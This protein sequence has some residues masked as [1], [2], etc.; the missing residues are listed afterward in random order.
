MHPERRLLGC[1]TAL[2]C[3]L[4]TAPLA[5]QLTR[6]DLFTGLAGLVGFFLAFG[7]YWL[8]AGRSSGL[9]Y[10][11]GILLPLPAALPGIWYGLAEQIFWDNE[12]YG[13]TMED[14]LELVPTVAMDPYNRGEM[15][16]TVGGVLLLA[17]LAALVTAR[18]LHLRRIEQYE[19]G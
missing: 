7:G 5:W 10:I 4:P 15:L 12:R 1:L 16:L 14:A 2:V 17:L 3:V 19:S 13:C 6:A 9:G 8:G 18:Y 11:L